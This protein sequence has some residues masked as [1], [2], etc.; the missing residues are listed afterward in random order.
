MDLA[1]VIPYYKIS[2]F[3]DT[4]DSLSA[5]SNKAFNLYIGNDASPDDPS[6]LLK[7]YESKLDFR[8]KRFNEN[9]GGKSLAGQWERCIAMTK[10][11]KW[12]MILGDDDYLRPDYVEMFYKYIQNIES[13]DIKVVRFASKLI[14][15][16]WISDLHKFPEL[17]ESTTFFYKRYLIGGYRSS[18]SEYVFR[19]KEYEKIGFR[20]LPLAWGSDALAWLEFTRGGGIY[21]INSTN[22]FI[23]VS[24]ESISRAGYQTEIKKYSRFLL[25]KIVI[26]EYLFLFIKKHRLPLL[27]FYEKKARGAGEASSYGF[28]LQ[29]LARFLYMRELVEAIKFSKRFFYYKFRK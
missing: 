21:S 6:L 5:Q 20:D 23:R 29:M 9:L 4:L 11:E 27:L 18:L 25:F 12:I 7:K 17:E 28:Y 15:G 16:N 2:F 8:Y 22:A 14:E 26:K 19:R 3:E 13:L 1:I 24:N 10:G